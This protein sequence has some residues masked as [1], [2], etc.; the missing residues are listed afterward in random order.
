VEP[1]RQQAPAAEANTVAVPKLA[2][3]YLCSIDERPL[4]RSEVSDRHAAPTVRLKKG[5]LARDQGMFEHQLAVR[6]IPTQDQA[7]RVQRK[8]APLNGTD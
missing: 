4:R 1:E 8:P 3:S 7:R 5:V 6:G 2:L